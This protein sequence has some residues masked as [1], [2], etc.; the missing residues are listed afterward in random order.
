MK[1][2]ELNINLSA[3]VFHVILL[4]RWDIANAGRVHEDIDGAEP[5]LGFLDDASTVVRLCAIESGDRCRIWKGIGQILHSRRVAGRE[6][7]PMT[8][9]ENSFG[10]GQA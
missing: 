2:G 7:H 4:Y 3:D 9:P 6:D 1:V 10:Q 8:L 5:V